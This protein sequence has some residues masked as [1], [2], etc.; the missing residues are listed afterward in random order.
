MNELRKDPLLN[1]WVA[2]FKDSKP[3]SFYIGKNDYKCNPTHKE[4]S[5]P[6]CLGR[7]DE[8]PKAIVTFYDEGQ[9]QNERMWKTRVIPW[10]N[11]V[12]QVEGELGRKGIG[13]YDR[14]NGIGA[15]EIII[16]TP[17]HNEQPEDQ[18]PKQMTYV[19]K[20]YKNRLIDLEQDPR[21]RY[22]FIYKEQ[23]YSLTESLNH[24]H[25]KV[26]APPIIP[27]AIKDEL[28]GARQ[29]YY[30][31]ERCI[32]CDIIHEELNIGKRILMET[33]DFVAFIPYAPRCAFEC[34]IVPKR[35]ECAYQN[36]TDSEIDDLSL[37][38]TTILKKLKKLLDNPPYYYVIHSAPNR[39]PRKDY[40]HTIGEDFHWHIEIIPKVRHITGF[41]IETDFYVL[42]TSPEDAA[43]FYEEVR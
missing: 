15:N 36:I 2:L 13:M 28:D 40:W 14:M 30:Y 33:R 37:V 25:S 21:L 39:I 8:T 9:P 12:F 26:I 43:K 29:F 5:C 10:T 35:H 34:W 23:S 38:L 18:G 17:N 31:K 11:F 22:T 32:F 20:T 7:E 24:A 19:L 6:L 42:H 1:R 41:E 16:E 4:G 3:V 27:K